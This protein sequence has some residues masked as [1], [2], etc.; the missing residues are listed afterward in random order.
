MVERPDELIP[1]FAEAGAEILVT[2]S[3]VFEY[4]NPRENARQLLR[5]ALEATE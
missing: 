4:G 5:S 3:A 2:G 1:A